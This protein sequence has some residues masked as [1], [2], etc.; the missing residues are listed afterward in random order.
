MGNAEIT[1]QRIGQRMHRSGVHRAKAHAAIHAAQRHIGARGQ[2]PCH[3]QTRREAARN[4]RMPSAPRYRP[5]DAPAGCVGLDAVRKRI[6]TRGSGNA[7]RHAH[8]KQW[9]DKRG[10]GH[11]MRA[12]DAFFRPSAESCT[13]AMGETSLPVP[14]VVGTHTSGV[15]RPASLPMPNTSPIFW[16][17][18]SNAATSLATSMALPATEADDEFGAAITRC[19]N[20]SGE[21]IDMR[22]GRHAIPHLCRAPLGAQRRNQR[23]AQVRTCAR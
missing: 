12:D 10:I 3:R 21:I 22:L 13:M 11:Q 23:I 18:S 8:R 7:R 17:P 16:R 9:I 14:D 2:H 20:G 1:A 15:L 6:E 19:G 4:A 5:A